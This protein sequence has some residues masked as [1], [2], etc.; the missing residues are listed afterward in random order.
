M[1]ESP[2][3]THSAHTYE[4]QKNVTYAALQRLSE[5]GE[6]ELQKEQD[7]KT[8]QSTAQQSKEKQKRKALTRKPSKQRCTE[9]G[10]AS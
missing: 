6:H 5:N 1:F 3:A 7:R 8:K 9:K 2:R 10:A 4:M